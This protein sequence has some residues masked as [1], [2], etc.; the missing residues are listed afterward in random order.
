MNRSRRKFVIAA[1][2]IA[3]AGLSSAAATYVG[4][5][6]ERSELRR[7]AEQIDRQLSAE[8]SQSVRLAALLSRHVDIRA[9]LGAADAPGAAQD[10][11]HRLVLETARFAILVANIDGEIIASG[12]QNPDDETAA[13]ALRTLRIPGERAARLSRRF[14]RQADGRWV[15]EV[16]RVIEE[17]GQRR[18][19]FVIVHQTLDDLALYWRAIPDS[20][21]VTSPGGDTLYT[22][23]RFADTDWNP[24]EFNTTTPAYGVDIRVARDP[25]ALLRHG[26]LGAAAG[27]LGAGLLIAA[28]SRALRR[29]RRAEARIRALAS[30]AATL[31]ARVEARTRALRREIQQ[32]EEA[33]RALKDSQAQLVRMAKFKVLNDLA[34]GL[35]HELSQPLFALEAALD[36]LTI[37]MREHPDAAQ[38]AL[39]KAQRFTRRMRR[40]LTT[41]KSFARNEYIEP[42]PVD[43]SEAV[44]AGLDILEH[45]ATRH[46]VA[47]RH[48]PPAAPLHGLATP[49]RLQ[50]VVVNLVSNSIDAVAKDGGGRIDITYAANADT[51]ADAGARAHEIHIRDNGPGFTDPE[52]AL[53]AFVS[54]KDSPNSLGL[55]LSIS[56]GI[57]QSFGGALTILKTQEGGAHVVLTLEPAAAE[58][59]S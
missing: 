18:R 17:Q 19:G 24:L 8:F 47:I 10:A 6:R 25:R 32:R 5:Q 56:A 49:T 52:A 53:T 16:A 35:S 37:N 51:G 34:R 48:V 41:I 11:L 46:H 26:G 20:M 58:G 23:A 54:T 9:A 15:F 40:I 1:F 4:I 59:G 42:V 30:S 12:L 45:E 28:L 31:E 36:T 55:G 2:C 29:R 44:T 39:D 27:L 43:L 21:T 57:L 7:L 13:A 50:Q 22:H 3:A 14:V 33:E 38:G